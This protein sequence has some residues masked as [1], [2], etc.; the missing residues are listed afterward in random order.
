V[1]KTTLKLIWGARAIG[2]IINRTE[3][4]THYLLEQGLIQAARKVGEQWT[5]SEVGLRRQFCADDAEQD[6]AA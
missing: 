3:R 4:Q 2:A 5:A 1:T 6:D